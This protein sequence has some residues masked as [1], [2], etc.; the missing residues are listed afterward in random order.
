MKIFSWM[1]LGCLFCL[2]KY[3]VEYYLNVFCLCFKCLKF[4]HEKKIKLKTVLIASISILIRRRLE[5]VF[6]T[7]WSRRIYSPYT[8]VFRRRLQDILIKTNI[9]VLVIRLQDVSPRLFKMSSR[10]LV[11]T[12]SRR[13]EDVFKTFCK[14]IFKTFSRRIIELI[15]SC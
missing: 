8:Y 13:F 15:C 10:R 12:S 6:K 5:D 11:K 3:L 2:W 9:F 4:L 1:L 7:S 14:D